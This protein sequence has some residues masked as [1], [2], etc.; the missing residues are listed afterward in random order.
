MRR[1]GQRVPLEGGQRL[2]GLTG[3][4]GSGKST[5]ARAIQDLASIDVTVIDQDWYFMARSECPEGANFCDPRWLF[6]ENFISDVTALARGRTALVPRLDEELFERMPPVLVHPAPVVLVTGMTILR[7]QEVD[8]QLQSR[9]YL[10]PGIDVIVKRKRERDA[11]VRKKPQW[12]I[13]EEIR[14]GKLEYEADSV[15]RDRSDV[16]VLGPEFAIENLVSR[17][18]EQTD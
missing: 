2:I 14:W 10:D 12:V 7:I 1:S 16:E 3:P 6:T 9:Y 5:L 15:L 4:S 13:D 18:L 17:L 8:L 11:F